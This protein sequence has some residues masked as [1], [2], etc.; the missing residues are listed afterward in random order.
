[1]VKKTGI[2]LYADDLVL[3]AETE[4]ELQLMLD[5]LCLWCGNN[6]IKVN[7]EKRLSTLELH[8]YRNHRL[9]SN[10]VATF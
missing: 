1:M 7:Q 6:K 4:H 10:A 3:L 9:I 8:L 5:T 2:L